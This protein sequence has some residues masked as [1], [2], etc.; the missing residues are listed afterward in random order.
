MW[1]GHAHGL[2]SL[3]RLAVLHGQ[4]GPH[5]ATSL[6]PSWPM[7]QPSSHGRGSSL[8][9][10]QA[11]WSEERKPGM[12]VAALRHSP[13]AP[14]RQEMRGSGVPAA[15]ATASPSSAQ[16][17]CFCPSVQPLLLTSPSF[18]L[19]EGVR[20]PRA[21]SFISLTAFDGSSASAAC[22]P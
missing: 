2:P 9:L 18:L 17:R 22:Q 1:S 19:F 10:H 14:C 8:L 7:T 13:A 20:W 16:S 15:G 4:A 3:L 12:S 5:V 6:D 21:H 11:D